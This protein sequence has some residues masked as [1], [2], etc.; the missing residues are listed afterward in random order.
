[1]KPKERAKREKRERGPCPLLEQAALI[2]KRKPTF[3]HAHARSATI[4]LPSSLCLSLSLCVHT[5]S[6]VRF[7]H[8]SPPC[9]SIKDP[10]EQMR[11]DRIMISPRFECEVSICRTCFPI[12]TLSHSRLRSL[13]RSFSLSISP[14]FLALALALAPSLSPSS[15]PH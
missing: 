6:P 13:S 5:L 11:Y 9:L 10:Q 1:M 15:S 14:H 8:P 3:L 7:K 4:I 2:K 12:C